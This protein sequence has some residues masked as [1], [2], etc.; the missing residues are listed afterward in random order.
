M[1]FCRFCHE[2]AQISGVKV[3]CYQ[4][5]LMGFISKCIKLPKNDLLFVFFFFFFFVF[6]R[7]MIK[8][9]KFDAFI[10]VVSLNMH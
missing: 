8:E 3:E 4:Y 5:I 10:R 6:G 2:A 9:T 1:P 7:E